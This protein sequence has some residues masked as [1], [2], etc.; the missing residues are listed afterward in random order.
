M[1]KGGDILSVYFTTG[2][3]NLNDTVHI[4]NKLTA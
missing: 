4:I 3:P 1:K 2:Y